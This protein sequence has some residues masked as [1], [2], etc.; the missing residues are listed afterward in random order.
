MYRVP[1]VP[2]DICDLWENTFHFWAS[3][4]HLASCV[5]SSQMTPCS[6]GNVSPSA[7]LP[8]CSHEVQSLATALASVL[9]SDLDWVKNT[10]WQVWDPPRRFPTWHR[11]SSQCP[12]NSRTQMFV[13]A[14]SVTVEKW[15]QPNWPVGI[16]GR[17]VQSFSGGWWKCFEISGNDSLLWIY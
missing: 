17:W 15:K 9:N 8:G 3:S 1:Q 14:F 6:P 5:S 2:V 10:S 11:K 7:L 16:D 4:K 13:V 12:Q